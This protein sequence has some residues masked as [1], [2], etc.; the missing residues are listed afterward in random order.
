MAKFKVTQLRDATQY[1]TAVIEAETKEEAQAKAEAD[2]CE[3][4]DGGCQQFDDR[5]IP[6]DEI[7]VIDET[8]AA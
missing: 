4:I 7:E 6:L 3:W 8:P 1:Y 5:E 2:E